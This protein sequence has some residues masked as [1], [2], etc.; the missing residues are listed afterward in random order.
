MTTR[1]EAEKNVN[2]KSRYDFVN[3]AMSFSFI[4]EMKRSGELPIQTRIQK[5]EDHDKFYLEYLKRTFGTTTIPFFGAILS[6][7]TLML[8]IM[9]ILFF[10]GANQYASI[11]TVPVFVESV[12]K[13]PNVAHLPT[14]II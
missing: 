4:P 11:Q 6:I 12:K 1:T 7:I 14:I 2:V 10:V 5:D 9:F 8:I 13:N 3:D